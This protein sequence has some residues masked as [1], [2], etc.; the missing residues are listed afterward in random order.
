M[1]AVRRTKVGARL[2]LAFGSLLALLLAVGSVGLAGTA[3]QREAAE[4]VRDLTQLVSYVET[5]RYYDADISGWQV[6]YAWDSYR[7][8]AAEAISPGS[9]NRAGFLADKEALLAHLRTTP[10]AVMTAAEQAADA[11][12]QAEWKTYFTS[13]DRAVELYRAGDLAAAE[14]E[15][16]GNGYTAYGRILELTQQLRDS[17]QQRSDAA[18]AEAAAAA[19]RSRTLLLTAMALAAV[20][21]VGLLVVVTRSLTRPLHRIVEQVRA[22]AAGD[23][24]VTPA[25]DG[26]DE[27]T[28]VAAALREAVASTRATVT[29]VGAGARQVADMAEALSRTATDLQAANT[30]TAQ[31][32][33]TVSATAAEVSGN[34]ATLAAGAEEMG[35]SIREIA[36]GT[37]AAAEVSRRAVETASTTSSA[38]AALSQASE[39]I[40]S[41]VKTITAIA[42][43]TNLLAL[44]ATIEAARAGDAGK[45][46]AVVA[47]EVKELAQQTAEATHDIVDKVA[48]IQTGTADAAA[49]IEEISSIIGSIDQHQSTIAAAV[50]EQTATTAEMARNVAAAAAGSEEIA[51]TVATV[52]GA[53]ESSRHHVDQV[54]QAVQQLTATVGDLR[55][56][57]DSFRV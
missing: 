34:V 13:D 30:E 32:T 54:A 2:S 37:A 44:N 12:M 1:S 42:E 55:A 18:Q 19:Q 47:S 33:G 21:A 22:I 45:G 27:L 52:A 16:L 51:G 41:V 29:G 46:F 7:L 50:E 36:H 40:A 8:G 28:D 56:S 48:A 24:T 17:A 53:S 10:T 43:Q 14:E 23:L 20:L 5:I 9:G 6:A 39:Q 4:H 11:E 25:V 26:A 38:V 57:V 3:R 35:T 49:A 31:R 15:I